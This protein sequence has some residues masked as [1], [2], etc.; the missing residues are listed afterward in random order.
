MLILGIETSCDETGVALYDTGRGLLSHA[1]VSQTDF[2]ASFAALVGQSVPA[3]AAPDSR[4]TLA[5]LLGEDLPA[6]D[7]VE[8]WQP[9]HGQMG[10]RT[11]VPWSGRTESTPSPDQAGMRI[12]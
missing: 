11:I 2:L 8:S 7:V 10:N 12:G 9:G 6:I 5:A 4:D 1:L 3:D